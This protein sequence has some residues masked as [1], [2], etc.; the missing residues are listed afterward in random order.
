LVPQ[1]PAAVEAEDE[2]FKDLVPLEKTDP[3]RSVQALLFVM[4][5]LS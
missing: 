2:R 1:K 3:L 5:I 4:S